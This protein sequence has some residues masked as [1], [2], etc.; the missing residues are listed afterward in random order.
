MPVKEGDSFI[1]LFG[2]HP[3]EM[4]RDALFRDL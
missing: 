2:I 4:G 3:Q 1:A